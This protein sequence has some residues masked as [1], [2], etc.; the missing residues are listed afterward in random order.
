MTPHDA[1]ALD[2]GDPLAFAKDRFRLPAGKTYLDGNSLGALPVATAVRVGETIRHQWGDD[3]IASW[4]GHDWIEAPFRV[5]AKLAPIVGARDGELLIA[6]S[7][8]VCLF[9]LLTA[10]VRARPDR[11]VIVT[12]AANFPTDLYVIEGAAS[13]L[14]CEVRRVPAGGIADAIDADVAVVTLTHVDYRSGAKYDMAAVNA[15]AK[16]AGA[17][18][19]WDLS[20]SAGA[21]ELDLNGSGCDLAVGCGYKYFNGGPGAPAFLFVAEELQKELHSPLQGWMG[22]ADPFAFSASYQPADGIG[23]YLTGTPSVLALAALDC[24][25]DTFSGI[26]MSAVAAKSRALSQ[27]FIEEVERG[28]GDKVEL[29]GPREPDARGSHVSFA[30][31][32]G[33]AVM[34]A[35]IDGGVIGDFRAPNL[36]RFGFAPLY[37]SYAEV[38]RAAELL[39]EILN[40]ASWDQP[41]FHARLKVT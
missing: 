9:K 15:A 11:R 27:L 28:C 18:T 32:H 35:L 26:L 22:H 34:Q 8:S 3:L 37:N 6:D 30:H 16:A 1:R 10:A 7:T 5:A 4:T 25:L 17:L 33:Y 36:I 20:H 29:A 41:R 39:T 19:L 24:G 14:G 40:S 23:Q 13:L 21:V 2:R 31:P 38:V 12:D